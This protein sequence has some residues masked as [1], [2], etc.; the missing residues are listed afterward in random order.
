MMHRRLLITEYTFDPSLYK[1]TIELYAYAGS[2][3]GW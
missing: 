3:C 2:C 1:S